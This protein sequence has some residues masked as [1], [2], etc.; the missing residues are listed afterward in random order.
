MAHT[1][2]HLFKIPTTGLRFFTVYGP[3]G[4]PDMAM[5]LFTEAIINNK[6]IKVFNNGKMSRDFTYIDDIVESM[7]R[8]FL[9]PPS[10]IQIPFNLFNIG[11]NKPEKLVDFIGEIESATQKIAKKD[12][13]PIQPGDIE[14]TY[15]DVQSLIKYIDYKPQTS[16]HE[17]ITNFVY[18]YKNYFKI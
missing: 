9:R 6:R 7:F 12:Y 10:D 11:N 15:A 3:W 17:G 1:Y 16:I 2:S 8:V 18:W 14:K 4:R 13:L 5:H